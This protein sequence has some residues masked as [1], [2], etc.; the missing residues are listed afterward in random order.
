MQSDPF[1]TRDA[2][3]GFDDEGGMV[4]GIAEGG[5]T[6][7]Q[8]TAAAGQAGP[9]LPVEKAAKL[10]LKDPE[11]NLDKM[12][13]SATDKDFEIA[14]NSMDDAEIVIDVPPM[15]NTFEDYF[16]GLTADSHSSFSI[17]T[18]ESSPLEGRM[19]RRGGEPTV[20]KIKCEPNGASGT[21]EAHLCF[22]LENEPG[23]SKFYKISCTSS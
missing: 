8:V 21:F 10:V 3:T 11:W 13:M 22:I 15:M 2:G 14:C 12:E 20:V 9:S 17:S 5:L 1:A 16:F 23:F 7:E 18:D 6:L 4:R 19:Q